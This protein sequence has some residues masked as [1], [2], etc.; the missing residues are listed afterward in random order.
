[1]SEAELHVLKARLRG[2]I[3]NKVRRA[4]Y[5]CVLPT[6][7]VY[8]ESGDVVLD[9]DS[10]V[11]ETIAYFFETFSRVGSAHQTVKTFRNEGL[12]FPSRIWHH[13]DAKVIFRPITASTAMRTLNNPR[14]AG[15]YAYGR[16]R[17]RRT[18]DGKK[19]HRK[20]DCRDWLACIPDAHPGY[21]TWD[22]YQENLKLLEANGRGYDVARKSP[23]REGSALLQGRAVCGRC[24]THFRVRYVSRRGKTESWYVCDRASGSR[25]APNCQSIAGRPIDEAVGVLVADTMTPAAVELALEIRR[26]I[27]ARQQEADQL[28]CRAIERAQVEADLAQRRF[29][30]I[31]PSN[32]LVADAL[33]ADW[34]D[35]LRA[36]AKAREERERF[37][38]EDQVAV[39]DAIRER[40]V[41]MTTDFKRLWADPATP[42][43]ERKRMLAHIIEDVTLIKCQRDG[44]TKI[45]VRFKG[46]KIETLTTR[47]PKSSAQQ[48]QTPPE[49]VALVDKLLDDHVYSKIADL[50][51]DRGLLPGGS[52]R[53]GRE[54]D[55]FTAKRVAYLTHTYGLRPR[56]DRLRDRG[57]LTKE[58]MADR[59][60]IHEHT[61]VQ[62]A[63]HGII[64]KY[65]YNDHAY[66]YEDPG[67]NPPAKQCSRW[68]RLIDR[69]AVVQTRARGSQTARI[70]PKEV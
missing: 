37:R 22:Q 35:K 25:A 62:W 41:A 50:L 8:N 56:Y 57:M 31:D 46:G 13:G 23:P 44:F 36:L 15:V 4:E 18:V 59:L 16:R 63:K 67:P 40:L 68:N 64:A 7:F 52:A 48:V 49:T 19:T 61:L 66:L 24:G 17:Y 28:R 21:I 32:R 34:N 11:R 65:S 42:N 53:P 12:R 55:R 9:P 54:N 38:H 14:Y 27:E 43:R 47:N 26:E 58:E 69:A 33:E 6:G 39:D 1:M 5:R 45:H 70:D 10:Q 29:M 3:L 60:D 51:N 20:R 2:G 30:M